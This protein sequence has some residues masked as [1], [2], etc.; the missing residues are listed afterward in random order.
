MMSPITP[1]SEADRI[2]ALDQYDILDTIEESDYDALTQ[3]AS[4]I[5]DTPISLISLIDKDRQWFKAHHGLDVRE[6]PRKFAFCAHAINE[7]N[8]LFQ[9]CDARLDERFHDNPLVTDEPRVI[10]YAGIPLVTEDGQALG[11]LCVIDHERRELNQKQIQSLKLL[12]KQTM[13]LME[14]RLKTKQLSDLYQE[15]EDRNTKLEHFSQ[16]AA[17]DLKSPLN[18]IIGLTQAL[19]SNTKDLLHAEDFELLTMVEQAGR[20]LHGMIEGMLQLY[21][22]RSLV[23]SMKEPV[24]LSETSKTLVSILDH[25]KICTLKV[26]GS[27][28]MVWVNR[29]ALDQLLINLISNAIKYSDKEHVHLHIHLNEEDGWYHLSVQDNGPG[30]PEKLLD[31]SFN[32]YGVGHDTDRFGRKGTGIGL[33]TLAELMK[34]MGGSFKAYNHPDGG[35]VFQANWPK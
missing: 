9:V 32:L 21:R 1:F 17:H 13:Q 12:G 18:V 8:K 14:L 7:P 29:T 22:N 20:R 19:K 16:N 28:N 3:L 26:D 33:Y 24:N 31:Q 23:L 15:L 2:L 5:C 10:F 34:D 11:T 25:Q 4:Q 6:T 27:V 30:L 35:A